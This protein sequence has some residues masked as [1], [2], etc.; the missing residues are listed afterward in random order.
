MICGAVR[1][2]WKSSK[3][4]G[5]VT[6]VSQYSTIHCNRLIKLLWVRVALFCV[7]CEHGL[8][9]DALLENGLTDIRCCYHSNIYQVTVD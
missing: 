5:I 4:L 6:M 9:M 8:T 7:V 3:V 1:A 2:W